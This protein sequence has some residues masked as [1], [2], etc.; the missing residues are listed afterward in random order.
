MSACKKTSSR[1]NSTNAIGVMAKTH[2]Q[3]STPKV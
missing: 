2:I 1:S 3:V